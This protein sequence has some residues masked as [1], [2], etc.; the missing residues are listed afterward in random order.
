MT[1]LPVIERDLRIRSRRW[2]TYWLRAGL[3]LA[4]V[5]VC[6]PQ[7]ISSTTGA[8]TQD[9]GKDV[10]NALAAALFFVC[11]GA[12]L[13]TSDAIGLERREETLGLLLLTRVRGMDVLL[14]KFGSSALSGLC[15]MT[16]FLPVLM[17][18]V[19]AGGVT[20]WEAFRTA[21][22]LLNTLFFALAAGLYASSIR[23]EQVK[24]AG[25][26]LFVVLAFT[27]V[28]WIFWAATPF[29]P[30]DAIGP[31]VATICAGDRRFSADPAAY[32]VSMVSV[33]LMGWLLLGAAC[34]QFGRMLRGEH[35]A[36][37]RPQDRTERS[38]HDTMIRKW[39]KFQSDPIGWAVRNQ[40]GIRAPLWWATAI[41]ILYVVISRTGIFFAPMA[42]WLF[43]AV[44][45]IATDALLAIA[46]G[47][48][49]LENSRS[50]QLE[51][52]LTTPLGA[53]SI[54]HSQWRAMKSLLGWPVAISISV[55]M[56]HSTAWLTLFDFGGSHTDALWASKYVIT[57]FFDIVSTIFDVF[58][59]CWVGMW[60][61]LQTR[62]RLAIAGWAAAVSTGVPALF[63][64]LFG[65]ILDPIV[66]QSFTNG[67]GSTS[68]A[69]ASIWLEQA[70]VLIYF[71]YAWLFVKRRLT[72]ELSGAPARSFSGPSLSTV[73]LRSS[74]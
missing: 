2:G 36:G 26:A 68:A 47:R 53:Q 67:N 60:V 49:F 74:P 44:C 12:C 48:F 69:L 65:I 41:I 43:Y 46:A 59:V 32:G 50:G 5:L 1:A 14:G 28:P 35:S 8:L 3:G 40:R 22:A 55:L 33:Q 37:Q 15:A 62:S 63:R 13:L 42:S 9:L 71:I 54:L 66:T 10:F 6:V 72:R 57:W 39:G 21:L 56:L 27:I 52:L 19:L 20:G 24:A 38:R 64:L 73:S 25:L 70:L 4:G 17:L 29:S 16:A 58:L 34:G 11:C 7:L 30:M 45:S 23:R 18:P 31:L 51:L 61:G